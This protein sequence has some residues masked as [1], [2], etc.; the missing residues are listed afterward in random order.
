MNFRTDLALEKSE[1]Y[2]D[3]LPDGVSCAVTEK[4]GVKIT[5]IEQ[6]EN[7]SGNI[8]Q[9]KCRRFQNHL[10][11]LTT[12]SELSP[13]PCVSCCPTRGRFLSPVSA[14]RT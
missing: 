9:S 3:G 11:F 1:T 2:G 7:L 14:T 10:S 5:R 4:D 8:L 6:S 13:T 12:G